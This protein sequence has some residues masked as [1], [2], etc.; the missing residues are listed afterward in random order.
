M[1][2]GKEKEYVNIYF[3]DNGNIC[4]PKKLTKKRAELEALIS[5]T[6]KGLTTYDG[7]M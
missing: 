7:K 3:F 6:D 5:R 1:S 4:N 2:C